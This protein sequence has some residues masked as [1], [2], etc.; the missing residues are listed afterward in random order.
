M[1]A[2]TINW[3]KYS[4]IIRLSV[5]LL[6]P[7]WFYTFLVDA[8]ASVPP[9]YSQ[10]HTHTLSPSQYE[11]SGRGIGPTPTLS[12]SLTA[13]NIDQLEFHVGLQFLFQTFGVPVNISRVST[14]MHAEMC[15]RHLECPTLLSDFNKTW[16]AQ[17]IILQNPAIQNISSTFL[18]FSV[19]YFPCWT[20]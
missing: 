12:L 9:Y 14:E 18:Q 4:E 16:N 5:C 11:S 2:Q 3:C 20:R 1:L 8:E 13:H 15:V 19:P 7:T 17:T 6:S 10:W